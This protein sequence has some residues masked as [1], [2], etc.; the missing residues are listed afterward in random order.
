M[1]VR[2]KENIGDLSSKIPRNGVLKEKVSILSLQEQFKI[3]FS[4]NQI[5]DLIYLHNNKLEKLSK[6]KYAFFEKMLPDSNTLLP[7]I[8]FSNFSGE[9]NKDFYE[10][11]RKMRKLVL[12]EEEYFLEIG[13]IATSEVEQDKIIDFFKNLDEQLSI[14]STKIECLKRL[15]LAY[16]QKN[17]YLI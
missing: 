4:L 12:K 8:R 2:E 3:S 1:I 9:W 17:A 7:S 14:Q 6:L 13:L 10:K 5:D 16:I 11:M 15:K